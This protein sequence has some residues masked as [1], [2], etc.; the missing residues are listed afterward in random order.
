MRA[1][2]AAIVLL[3]SATLAHGAHAEVEVITSPDR[4]AVAIDRSLLRALF[5]MRVRQWP[6]GTTARVFVLP[7]GNAVHD[8]FCREVLGTYP[9]VLRNTWDRGVF[10]G[11]GFAPEAVSSQ[12]EMLDKVR[13][14]RGAIGY[15]DRQPAAVAPLMPWTLTQIAEGS[16]P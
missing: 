2:T 5:T 1:R 16:Q 13:R 3:L 11:T 15:V 12:A 10:T 14:T 7:D 6:D 8:R 9:Y 4:S